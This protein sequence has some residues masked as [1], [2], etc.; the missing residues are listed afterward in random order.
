MPCWLS[1]SSVPL[2]P[3]RPL[4]LGVRLLLAGRRARRDH[5]ATGSTRIPV[6]PSGS[7]AG[8][9]RPRPPR[10][11]RAAVETLVMPEVE[12]EELRPSAGAYRHRAQTYVV[13][14][15]RPPRPRRD[16][17]DRLPADAVSR[18]GLRSW[19]REGGPPAGVPGGLDR[20]VRSFLAPGRPVASASRPP[21]TPSS[22]ALP[23][24]PPATVMT[25]RGQCAGRARG[26]GPGHQAA[27]PR[28]GS[29]QRD[30]EPGLLP[31]T[32]RRS[33]GATAP[34]PTRW[35]PRAQAQSY[36][37]PPGTHSTSP[38][39]AV[40]VAG[41]DEEQV[42]EPVEVGDRQLVHRLGRARRTPPRRSA[43]RGV[44]RCGRRAGG[45]SRACRR[46]G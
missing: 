23:A 27:W 44:R 34:G 39:L 25:Q 41:Q 14:G 35:V 31:A 19:R 17:G 4:W 9:G 46:R 37:S 21:G 5:A 43:R 3:R 38:L 22:R 40:R 7:V 8:Q 33:P 10:R 20:P 24:P 6:A 29:A 15:D 1:S 13:L 16:P 2:R 26:G 28:R 12:H 11:T 30:G 42:G 36:R 32:R 45:P 18:L